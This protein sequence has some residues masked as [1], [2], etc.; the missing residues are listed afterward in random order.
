M[1][2]KW[3]EDFVALAEVSSFSRAAESRNV[4][5]S[6]FSRRIRQLEAWLGATLIIRATVPAK[7]TAAG[8]NFLPVA[9]ETIR[10]FHGIRETLRPSA[11]PRLVRIAAL[12]TLTLTFFPEW[13]G[14]LEE[15]VGPL[16]TSFIPDRGG[17][18][19]NIEAMVVDEA[20]LF[21]TYSHPQVPL[22][23]DDAG[24]EYLIIGRDRLVPVAARQVRIAGA[25]HAG[26]G[27][28]DRAVASEL[29]LPCLSYGSASFFG[30]A[31][32]HLLAR[33]PPFARR[34]V[35]ENTISAGLKTVAMTGSGL[36]WLP[37]S[38]VAEELADGRLVAA[39]ASEDWL[40]D[41]EIR[42]Y[43]HCANQAKPVERMWRAA[44]QI[45]SGIS[46]S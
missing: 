25:L 13:L 15:A 21:L 19:S 6:A 33:R 27:I 29:E 10:T 37:E 22:R 31:L 32:G 3:L 34:T 39:S 41:L 1:E 5:Q 35:H 26:A 42:L 45:Q 30:V 23:L 17:F 4:T 18:D 28:L 16:G 43:R 40:L 7:L 36:C 9:Q 12:H 20:D 24:F 8:H 46:S 11:E 2:I 14:R 44:A 38:L